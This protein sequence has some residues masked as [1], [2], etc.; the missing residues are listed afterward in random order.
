MGKL[1][2]E[3]TVAEFIGVMALVL[4]L[5]YAAGLMIRGYDSEW[6][7]QARLTFWAGV[8]FLFGLPVYRGLTVLFPQL[9]V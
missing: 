2:S 7:L 5:F 9:P 4:A 8:F 1:I 6:P 3:L